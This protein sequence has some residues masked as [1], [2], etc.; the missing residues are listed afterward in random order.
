MLMEKG[1]KIQFLTNIDTD[2]YSK[3][4]E[5]KQSVSKQRFTFIELQEIIVLKTR[6]RMY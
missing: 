3:Q 1:Y 6:Y 5:Y 4:L 2:A